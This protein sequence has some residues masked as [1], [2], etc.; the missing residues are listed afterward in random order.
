MKPALFG[1][2]QLAFLFATILMGSGLIITAFLKEIP[3]RQSNQR[4]G[5]AMAE[6]GVPA[7]EL[8]AE[9]V[10]QE[11]AAS[12]LEPIAEEAGREY[13]ASGV[14]GGSSLPA[15]DEPQLVER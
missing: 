4:P 7:P 11:Y 14:P 2:I 5:A 9:P 12:V 10:A 3:L 15:R 8:V 13:A 6:G 1:G